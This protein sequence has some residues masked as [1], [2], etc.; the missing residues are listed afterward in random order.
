VVDDDSSL[1]PFTVATSL[2]VQIE[3]RA[4]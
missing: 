2:F 4:G 1:D 3:V